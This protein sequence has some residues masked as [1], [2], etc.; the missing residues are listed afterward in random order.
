MSLPSQIYHNYYTKK[1]IYQTVWKTFCITKQISY[2]FEG[3]SGVP[4][5]SHLGPILFILFINDVPN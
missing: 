5:D 2:E 3:T 1:V 4:Q